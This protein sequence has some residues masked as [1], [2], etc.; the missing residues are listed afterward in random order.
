MGSALF[1][2]VILGIR[3]DDVRFG[4]ARR[5]ESSTILS[6]GKQLFNGWSIVW[7]YIVSMRGIPRFHYIGQVARG[8]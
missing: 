8:H 1:A 5:A 7:H 2:R 3:F 4:S 6:D